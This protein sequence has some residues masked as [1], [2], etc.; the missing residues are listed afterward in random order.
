M[1]SSRIAKGTKFYFENLAQLQ[2]FSEDN[3]NPSKDEFKVDLNK[4]QKLVVTKL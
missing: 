4:H 2:Q 3:G 1:I